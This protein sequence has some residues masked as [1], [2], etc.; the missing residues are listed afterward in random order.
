MRQEWWYSL[1]YWLSDHKAM[2]WSGIIG[3]LLLTA[4]PITVYLVKQNQQPQVGAQTCQNVQ[5]IQNSDQTVNVVVVEGE[6]NWWRLIKVDGQIVVAGPQSGKVFSNLSLGA[7][8]YQ[9]QASNDQVGW[10]S[11]N[12][13]FEIDGEMTTSCK[14]IKVYNT[15]GVKLSA[16]EVIVNQIVTLAV[17]GETSE[18][19]SLSKARFSF[20]GGNTWQETTQK[21]SQGEFYVEWTIPD[22]TEINLEA[23]IYHPSLGWR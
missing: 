5:V 12:C 16:D 17:T 14:E 15:E 21:N 4:I 1:K 23:Q 10:T 7:G 18:P 9:M 3:L 13:V 2:V 6:A 22:Q 11:E 20:D 8:E 19:Q